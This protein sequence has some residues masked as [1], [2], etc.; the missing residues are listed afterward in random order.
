MRHAH[1]TCLFLALAA[2]GITAGAQT[3][4]KCEKDGK[5]VYQSEPCAAGRATTVKVDAGPSA[6]EVAAARQRAQKEMNAADNAVRN[7]AAQNAAR[8]AAQAPAAGGGADCE[9][10]AKRYVQAS[11]MRNASLGRARN[12]GGVMAGSAEDDRIA[13]QQ[14]DVSNAAAAMRARGCK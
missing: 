8:A 10:L 11:N 9:T 13:S 2:L 4:H 7:A 3:I 12:G 6:D 14:L 5:V 1:H